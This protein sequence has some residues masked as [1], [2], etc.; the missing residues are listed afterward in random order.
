MKTLL[1]LLL[2]VVVSPVAASPYFRI[3]GHDAG[4]YHPQVNIGACADVVNVGHSEQC[5][6]V[7]VI[8]HSHEDGYLLLPGE[9][10]TLLALGYAASGTGAKLVLGPSWNIA[11][12][13]GDALY[14]VVQAFAPGSSIAQEIQGTLSASAQGGHLNG[15]FGPAFAYDPLAGPGGHGYFRFLAG[16]SWKF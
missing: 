16:A 11:P 1:A 2:A 5:T 8:N 6:M 10:W 15:A 12:A 13:M 7:G 9:D 14:Q 3:M 4:G